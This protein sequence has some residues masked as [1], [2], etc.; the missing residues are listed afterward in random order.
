MLYVLPCSFSLP[1]WY[2]IVQTYHN[3]V[4][5]VLLLMD[6]QFGAIMNNIAMNIFVHIFWYRYYM[7]QKVKLLF[8]GYIGLA[9][10]LFNKVLHEN[11]K[12]I[13]FLSKTK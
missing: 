7:F 11:E 3:Y 8:I 9:K 1:I 13:L 2:P 10:S 6:I 4:S 12:F 5:I